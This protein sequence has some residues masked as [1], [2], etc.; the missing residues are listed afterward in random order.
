MC[1]KEKQKQI[2]TAVGWQMESISVKEKK[3]K[4]FKQ[5]SWPFEYGFLS[6]EV[7]SNAPWTPI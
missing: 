5:P 3:K 4:Y 7:H 6:Y 2:M 1:T